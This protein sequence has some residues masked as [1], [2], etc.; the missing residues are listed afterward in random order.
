MA[1]DPSFFR[2]RFLQG[3]GLAVVSLLSHPISAQESRSLEDYANEEGYID[4]EGVFQAIDDRREGII[5]QSLLNRVIRY[6]R[7]DQPVVDGGSANPAQLISS[8]KETL[9][10]STFKLEIQEFEERSADSPTKALDF[11]W[12]NTTQQSQLSETSER[13]RDIAVSQLFTQDRQHVDIRNNDTQVNQATLQIDEG[14]VYIDGA[15]LLEQLLVGASLSFEKSVQTNDT[16]LSRYS[17]DS[18]L[19]LQDASGYVIGDENAYISELEIQWERPDGKLAEVDIHTDMDVSQSLAGLQSFEPS[20]NHFSKSTNKSVSTASNSGSVSI[21]DISPS[22]GTTLQGGSTETFD[23]SI[24]Y[25]TGS[26]SSGELKISVREESYG[27]VDKTVSIDQDTG[28]VDVSISE[29]IESSWEQA[30]VIVNLYGEDGFVSIDGTERNYEIDGSGGGS[31]L[32]DLEVTGLEWSPSEPTPTDDIEFSVE[33]INTGE[34]RAESIEPRVYVDGD[35]VHVPPTMD[36]DPG[37]Q[38]WSV[39]TGYQSFDQGEYTARAVVDPD[40]NIAEEDEGNNEL[41]RSLI[42]GVDDVDIDAELQYIDVESGTYD[43]GETVTTTA[44]IENTGNVAHTY[45][46]GYTV[47]DSTGENYTNDETTGQPITLN[48]GDST[49]VDLEWTVPDDAREGDYDVAVVVWEE[50][51]RDALSTRLDGEEQTNSFTVDTTTEK[52]DLTVDAIEWT[53]EIVTRSDTVTLDVVVSNQGTA[54]ASTF[55]IDLS[56]GS[57]TLSSTISGLAP[58][59]EQNV[60]VGTWTATGDRVSVTATVDP[61]SQLKETNKQNNTLTRELTIADSQSEVTIADIEAGTRT[62]S[63]GDTATIRTDIENTGTTGRSVV[64][65]YLL[66]LPDGTNTQQETTIDI[67]AGDTTTIDSTWPIRQSYPTGNYD[68]RVEAISEIDRSRTFAKT[69]QSNVFEVTESASPVSVTIETE[70]ASGDPVDGARITLTPSN[71]GRDFS[72]VSNNGETQFNQIPSGT[73][74]LVADSSQLN[75]K[76]TFGLVVDGF[77]DLTRKI[78]FQPTDAIYGTVFNSAGQQHIPS[79]TVSIPKLQETAQTDA[80][81]EFV[82]ES[83]IPDGTY[84]FEI[85][86][87]PDTEIIAE[88]AAQTFS[89]SREVRIDR[90]VTFDVSVNLKQPDND[91]SNLISEEDQL[92][93]IV[94]RN[95]EKR[96]ILFPLEQQF[97]AQYGFV[98][99]IITGIQGFLEDIRE[100]LTNLDD[101]PEMIRG[102]IKLIGLILDEPSIISKLVS[103]MVN[104]ILEKQEADNPFAKGTVDYQAFFG[105]WI[106]GYGGIK[107]AI[108]VFGTKGAGKASKIAKNSSKLTKSVDS[109]KANVSGGLPDDSPLNRRINIC[110]VTSSQISTADSDGCLHKQDIGEAIAIKSEVPEALEV[111]DK[112]RDIRRYNGDL[113]GAN[114]FDEWDDISNE[115][116]DDIKGMLNEYMSANRIRLKDALPAEFKDKFISNPNVPFNYYGDIPIVKRL[117]TDANNNPKI[118]AGDARIVM[119]DQAT[120]YGLKTNDDW[121]FDPILIGRLPSNSPSGGELKIFR[122]YEAKIGGKGGDSN[123]PSHSDALDETQGHLNTISDKLK[124]SGDKLQRD[125]TYAGIPLK[126]FEEVADSN[127]NIVRTIATKPPRSSGISKLKQFD[128]NTQYTEEEM[129]RVSELLKNKSQFSNKYTNP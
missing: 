6:W 15:E 57:E 116:I 11:Q 81:G 74:D 117:P 96:D 94:V 78:T 104:D 34:A 52:P 40:D 114:L 123:I 26:E 55:A 127:E 51:N 12:D 115:K 103:M 27:D 29:R 33:V 45:F 98:K 118:L 35:L 101:I 102:I 23:L 37:E 85:T 39:E 38:R 83:D 108:S 73:Y 88:S 53:P 59:D 36:L 14:P 76:L 41:T 75:Q 66:T 99:G 18:H 63:I 21:V 9:G 8:H 64:V 120:D 91:A 62:Y 2:R 107:I 90:T 129:K 44:T 24:E 121:E 22:T 93:S 30:K 56:V 111:L 70:T 109:L 95:L 49:T 50:D 17:I 87:A 122:I 119:P 48:S 13:N 28:T 71:G 105:A 7:A 126:K 68:L 25:D 60:E 89:K 61:E 67:A 72:A 31:Q 106:L 128:Y 77:R 42:L 47:F 69:S 46:V 86:V 1:D 54:E 112:L 124:D 84:E 5:T 65:A 97:I 125:Q 32:S 10:N 79:A 110:R 4:D 80:K 92:V 100:L 19:R 3:S 16:K 58:G 43:T 82:F 113:R 20:F